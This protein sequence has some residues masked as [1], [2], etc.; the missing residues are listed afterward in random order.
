[1]AG[2]CRACDVG[3]ITTAHELD[4]L[5]GVA[6]AH[7]GRE[8]AV[9]AVSPTDEIDFP[10]S[11]SV[12]ALHAVSVANGTAVTVE[13][14]VVVAYNAVT[15][16]TGSLFLQDAGGGRWSG[17][18]LFCTGSTCNA[19]AK[20]LAPGDV[21]TVSGKYTRYL[22]TTP[23]IET[24]VAPVKA[25]TPSVVRWTAVSGEVLDM[26]VDATDAH[27]LPY[28]QAYVKVSGAIT[29][30]DLVPEELQAACPG[31]S[32]DVT[33]HEGFQITD[34]AHQLLVG[35]LFAPAYTACVEGGCDPCA[36]PVTLESAYGAVAGVARV[37]RG[38]KIQIAPTS[39]A[40]LVAPAPPMP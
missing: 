39:D 7:S 10:R 8:G 24:N 2:G 11:R 19:A 21:V 34:G 27:F 9:V 28:N 16:S 20:A 15:S 33:R 38:G 14:A 32:A 13:N 31:A 5:R 40:D 3:A 17:I 23:E 25:A 36:N 18:Q 22:G 35:D 4:V 37:G 29:V 30:A 26:A 6:R 1:V 12:R